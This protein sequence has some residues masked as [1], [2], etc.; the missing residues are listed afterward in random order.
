MKKSL[1]FVTLAGLLAGV[2]AADEVADFRADCAAKAEPALAAGQ[3]AVEGKDGWLFL[4]AELRSIGAGKFWGEDAAKVSRATD[5]AKADPLPAIADFHQ[6][7]KAA[8]IELLFVPV[9]EK[10]VIYPDM[11]SDRV[12]AEGGKA[13]RLDSVNQEFYELLRKERVQVFDLTD[14]FL[15]ARA[16]GGPALY[17]RQD[18]HWSGQACVVAAQRLAAE[19]KLMEWMNALPQKSYDSKT[20]E[21]EI[22]GDLWSALGKADVP[23]EKLPL[24]F[25]T[26]AGKPVA[27]DKAS[28]ILLLGDSHN[29][30]FHGGGDMQAEGAGLADQLAL[31][32]GIPIDVLGVRGSGAT[33]S[34]INLYRRVKENPQYLS[35]KKLVIWCLSA[36][37]FTEATGWSKVPVK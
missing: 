24:R 22:T 14:A 23:K 34:R 9:P 12:K 5:P 32:L 28:P 20:V 10:A 13:P 11:I 26:E 4:A 25:V 1:L 31:E 19:I 7:L 17:C 15:E 6:Q 27:D 2:T 18:T 8:G 36:R 33:P 37:E 29:L 3:M 21:T 35:Q 16:A 30:I